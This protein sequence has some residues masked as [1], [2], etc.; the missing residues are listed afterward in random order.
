VSRPDG[1]WR[2]AKFAA[3]FEPLRDFGPSA[4]FSTHLPPVT[5]DSA[6]LSATLLDAP[7]ADPFTGP[8]QAALEAMLRQFE[9]A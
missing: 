2:S 4:V 3:S 6:A 9:P 8:D 7:Q 5:G 1:G